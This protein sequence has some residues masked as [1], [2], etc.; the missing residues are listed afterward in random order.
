MRTPLSSTI[1][2]TGRT[3]VA[4]SIVYSMPAQPPFFTPTRKPAT[5]LSERAMIAF[6]RSAAASV[7]VKTLGLALA[8]PDFLSHRHGLANRLKH[9]ER[10]ARFIRHATRIPRRV[11]HKL[12]AHE[13]Y[14]FHRADRILHP[15]RHVASDGAPRRS[16][17]HLHVDFPVVVD[18]N[19]INEP[20]LININGDF[21]VVDRLQRGDDALRYVLQLFLGDRVIALELLGD[22]KRV[23]A[24]LRQILV[25][26]RLLLIIPR[27]VLDGGLSVL[28]GL[29]HLRKRSAF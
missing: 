4:Y 1:S 8:I 12:H 17:G 6:T 27:R 5:G 23:G 25:Q 9:V 24:W 28:H 13:A 11:E 10:H 22:L 15:A 16:Q 19:P 21:G 3:S 2:S 29:G 7:S 14:A 20:K 18:I 26:G